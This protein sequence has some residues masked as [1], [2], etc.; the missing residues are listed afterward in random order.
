MPPE[1]NKA[2]NCGE[3]E[4]EAQEL[5]SN[6]LADKKKPGAKAGLFHLVEKDVAP[7]RTRLFRLFNRPLGHHLDEVRAVFARA[8][9]V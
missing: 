2:P 6:L 4:A 1:R 3:A 7:Y 9:D 5:R 8:M